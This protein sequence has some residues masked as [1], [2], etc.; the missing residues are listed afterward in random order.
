[1]VAG[2]GALY[3]RPQGSR[4]ENFYI[5]AGEHSTPK[6]ISNYAN[7]SE[8]EEQLRLY[9]RPGKQGI[10]KFLRNF[11]GRIFVRNDRKKV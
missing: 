11:E 5:E 6:S 10:S 9:I 8:F 3:F 4:A 7:I 1:M 2:T